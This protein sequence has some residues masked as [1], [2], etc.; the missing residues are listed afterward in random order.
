MEAPLGFEDLQGVT[1]TELALPLRHEGLMTLLTVFELIRGISK[2]VKAVKRCCCCC[3][4]AEAVLTPGVGGADLLPS[5]VS[6]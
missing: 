6:T 2:A 1:P 5:R 3:P 4:R